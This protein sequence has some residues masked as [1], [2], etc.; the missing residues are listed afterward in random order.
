[1]DNVIKEIKLQLGEKEVS[2]TVEQAKKLKEALDEMFGKEIIKEVHRRDWWVYPYY[3]PWWTTT[4][5]YP[6]KTFSDYQ[7]SG[8]CLA[9]F[10]ANTNA[11]T[12]KVA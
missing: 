10:D 4:S 7:T 3:Y 12:L 2:L 11:M 9:S 6:T 5:Y 1:M 8:G